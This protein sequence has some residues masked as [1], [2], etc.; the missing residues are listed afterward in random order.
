MLVHLRRAGLLRREKEPDAALVRE[1]FQNTAARFTCALCGHAG[2]T[3]GPA[4]DDLDDEDW[5]MGRPC[6]TCGKPIPAERLE[7]FPQTRLCVP[8]QQA[9]ETGQTKREE[10]YCPR[11]GSIMQVRP[12]RGRGLTGYALICPACGAS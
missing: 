10:E 1:L 3:V 5:G 11:C 6:E 9:D 4:Q 2:L 12:S 7:L 8:C